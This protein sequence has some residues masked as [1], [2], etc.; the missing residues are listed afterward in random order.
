MSEKRTPRLWKAIE[1]GLIGGGTTWSIIDEEEEYVAGNYMSEANA[2]F[3]VTACNCHDELLEAAK[4]LLEFVKGRFPDDFKEGGKGFT[5]PYHKAL[6][7]AIQKAD[8][9]P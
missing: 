5:C 1:E 3:I 9:T 4:N 2:R 8:S 7:A 6:E